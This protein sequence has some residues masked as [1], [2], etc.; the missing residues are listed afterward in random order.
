M[1]ESHVTADE[2]FDYLHGELPVAKDAAVAMHLAECR[3]CADAR[4]A[5]VA[6][7]EMVRAVAHK[8]ERA[9]P[10]SVM[11]SIRAAAERPQ[12]A[13][14]PIWFMRP[15][16]VLPV[17]LAAGL[18]IWLGIRTSAIVQPRTTIAAAYLVDHH[19]MT[20]AIAPFA[21]DAPVPPVFAS[22]NASH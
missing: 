16:V 15:A 17:A 12:K 9:V 2:I 19:T 7:S 11:S 10:S 20:S 14:R 5:E 4:E 22:D 8:Q 3:T 1:N 13:M 21:D 18:V 6:L